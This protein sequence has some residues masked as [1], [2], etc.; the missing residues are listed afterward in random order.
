MAFLGV[1]AP[2]LSLLHGP[3]RGHCSPSEAEDYPFPHLPNLGPKPGVGQDPASSGSFPRLRLSSLY[4]LQGMKPRLEDTES[5]EK[6]KVY[7]V[8]E[9]LKAPGF[10]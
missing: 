5:H 1:L 4:P 6:K 9:P 7:L 8:R 10:C 2:G 3:S